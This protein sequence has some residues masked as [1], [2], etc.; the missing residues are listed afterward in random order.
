M[1]RCSVLLCLLSAGIAAGAMQDASQF[2]PAFKL[3]ADSL[4]LSAGPEAWTLRIT[5]SGGFAGTFTDVTITSQGTLHCVFS[6]KST[7]RATLPGM[8]LLPLNQLALLP[9]ISPGESSLNSSCMDCLKY[10][11]TLRRREMNGQD[12]V[13]FAYWDDSTAAKASPELMRITQAALSSAR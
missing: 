2:P 4:G 11:V 5:R 12:R 13:Y 8:E 9:V 1:I 10:R 6:T 3:T 7:C